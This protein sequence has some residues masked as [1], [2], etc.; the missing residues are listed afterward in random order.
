MS[1]SWF[2]ISSLV[3]RSALAKP[4]TRLYP[5][6]KRKPYAKTRGHIKFK[7]NDCTFCTICATKCPTDA[8]VASKN[9]KTWAIDH[10]LC[11]LCGNCVTDC[12]EG[13]IKLSPQPWP[14]MLTKEVLT[15]RKDYGEPPPA[16]IMP[17]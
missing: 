16:I 14:P 11:I 15:F 6:E 8:I 5:F 4:A 12:R 10:S 13:C 9:D 3:T 1:W 17:R 7:I 2:R